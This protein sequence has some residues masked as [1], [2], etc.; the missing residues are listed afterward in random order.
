M[1]DILHIHVLQLIASIR[2]H[3]DPRSQRTSF[4]ALEIHVVPKVSSDNESPALYRVFS[5]T[6]QLEKKD[7]VVYSY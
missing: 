5:H 3:F 7:S 6:G 4:A 1:C 2:Q